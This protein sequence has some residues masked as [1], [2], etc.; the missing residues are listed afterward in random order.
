MAVEAPAE[1]ERTI[2]RTRVSVSGRVATLAGLP[3]PVRIAA[4]RGAG[5]ATGGL[6]AA[7]E[8]VREQGVGLVLVL[9][10][11]GSDEARVAT[12]LEAFGR[13]GVP[14]FVMVG[15]DDVAEAVH[16]AFADRPAEG[17]VIDARGLR[18]LR[19]GNDVLL[20]ASGAVDGRYAAS[21]AHCG[22]NEDDLEEVEA[23]ARGAGRA[24]LASWT[25]PSGGG[26]A[27]VGRGFAGIDAGD[28]AIAR[29]A[30]AAHARGGI[31]AWPATRALRPSNDQGAAV[32]PVGTAD[33]G[34]R[35]VVARI[36]G[37]G[38]ES[39]DGALVPPAA[40]LLELGPGGLA[41]VGTAVAGT[42]ESAAETGPSAGPGAP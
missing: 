31:F 17:P 15:G 6:A 24:F 42:P 37:A 28:P 8:G 22:A 19:F 40:A 36:A 14:T 10:G 32:L 41:F 34:L 20:L 33:P 5:D 7:I 9:G 1:G 4:F 29:L 21:D 11:L 2:G 3:S 25:A 12:H 27:A 13:L 26:A 35:L 23:E 39:D 18:A 30:S 38:E 16:D